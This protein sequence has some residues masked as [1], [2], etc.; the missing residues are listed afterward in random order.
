MPGFALFPETG[1]VFRR[2][3]SEQT[4]VLP[5]ELGSTVVPNLPTH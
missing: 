3:A 5:A 4:R 1:E 2:R